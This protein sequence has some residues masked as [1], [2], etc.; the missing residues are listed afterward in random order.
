MPAPFSIRPFGPGDEFAIVELHRAAILAL[1]PRLYEAELTRAGASILR[2]HAAK[3]A[4]RFCQA[5]GDEKRG[6]S[7]FTTHSGRMLETAWY[8]KRPED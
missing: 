1:S 5:I 7:Q 2:V 6:P 3:S 8:E 4:W